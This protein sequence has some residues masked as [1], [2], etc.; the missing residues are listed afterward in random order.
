MRE[1]ERK[2]EMRMKIQCEKDKNQPARIHRICAQEQP[3]P[4]SVE[5]EWNTDR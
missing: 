1:R 3:L 5:S 2:Y 4:H